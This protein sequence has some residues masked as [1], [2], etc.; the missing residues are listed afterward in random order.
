M[1]EIDKLKTENEFLK[2]Q[3]M[4]LTEINVEL[5][6]ECMELREELRKSREYNLNL[7]SNNQEQNDNLKQALQEI[8][9]IVKN[10]CKFRCTNDCL[11]TKKHCGY[12]KILQ[13]ISEVQEWQKK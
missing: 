8:K 6:K 7:I 13:K 2:T 10:T 1:E 11:G 5:T 12:G 9:E 4:Y 3:N